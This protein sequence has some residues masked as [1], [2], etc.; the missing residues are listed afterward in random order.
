MR[1]KPKGAKYRN[2][3]ARD[4]DTLSAACETVGSTQIVWPH[5][6]QITRL[7][8]QLHAVGDVGGSHL[9]AV[10]HRAAS[11]LRLRLPSHLLPLQPR[12]PQFRQRE[13]QACARGD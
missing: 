8:A 6:A 3:T 10:H 13:Q 4:G 2:L 1:S 12:T 11:A 5:D 7:T 9:Q